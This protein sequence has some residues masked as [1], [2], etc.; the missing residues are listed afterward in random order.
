LETLTKKR[1]KRKQG[2]QRNLG[3]A[4]QAS[5]ILRTAIGPLP[6]FLH[7]AMF[8]GVYIT[9]NPNKTNQSYP[10]PE[11]CQ[12]ECRV[13]PVVHRVYVRPGLLDEILRDPDKSADRQKW[14]QTSPQ[15]GGSLLEY[16]ERRS[17]VAAWS[18]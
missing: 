18:P 17:R 11:G 7:E 1:A 13:P 10:P 8:R 14:T 9:K 4:E 3:D 6:L 16:L 5:K 12:A 2:R 15:N